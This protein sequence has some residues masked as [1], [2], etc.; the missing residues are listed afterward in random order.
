MRA[1]QLRRFLRKGRRFRCQKCPIPRKTCDAMSKGLWGEEKCL[2]RVVL[3]EIL[4][5]HTEEAQ[6]RRAESR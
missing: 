5:F 3:L 1:G 6:K 4:A 2:L